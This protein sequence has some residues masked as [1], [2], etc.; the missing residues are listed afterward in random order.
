MRMRTSG[1]RWTASAGGRDI[2][3]HSAWH[4]MQQRAVRGCIVCIKRCSWCF[5]GCA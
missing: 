2:H 5:L 3:M 1:L 4:W